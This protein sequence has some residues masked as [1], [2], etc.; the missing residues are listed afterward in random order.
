MDP[1]PHAALKIAPRLFGKL[2]GGERSVE[3]I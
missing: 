3:L 1:D 2:T